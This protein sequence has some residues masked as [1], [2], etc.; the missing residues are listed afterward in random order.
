[1]KRAFLLLLL[2]L[3][4]AVFDLR[5]LRAA[6]DPRATQL[7]YESWT[8]F[9]FG[10]SNCFIGAGAHGACFPSGGGLSINVTGGKDATLSALFETR[11]V[12]DGTISVQIDQGDPILIPDPKCSGPICA[13][14]VQVDRDFIERLRRS[15]TITIEATDTTHQR[16]SLVLSLAGFAK[17]YDGPASAPGEVHERIL[18]P[19]KYKEMVLREEER[20]KALECK[21]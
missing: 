9:C 15:Q 6:N 5:G 21:E 10:D 11:R 13:G 14:K 20:R 19:E 17:A 18:S 12:I 4:C 8:K 16:N 1:M 2:I 3:T 7:T